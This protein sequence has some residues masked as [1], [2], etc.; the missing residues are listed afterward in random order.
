[1]LNLNLSLF[2]SR[3]SSIPTFAPGSLV[4]VN[5]M[6][7]GE[8]TCVIDKITTSPYFPEC[9]QGVQRARVV[10]LAGDPL[11]IDYLL[12][13]ELVAAEPDFELE[14]EHDPEY[15]QYLHDLAEQE[16][17]EAIAG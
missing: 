16:F 10:N 7:R 15:N 13:E 5:T 11:L 9:N 2:T 12:I 4:V 6:F 8:Q 1:M 14:L 3:K 17:M